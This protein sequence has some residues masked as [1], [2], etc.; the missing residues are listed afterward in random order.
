MG[1]SDIS[2]IAG[3]YTLGCRCT[4]TTAALNEGKLQNAERGM[5]W[6]VEWNVEWNT[7]SL[8]LRNEGECHVPSETNLSKSIH[9]SGFLPALRDYIQSTSSSI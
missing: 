5:E 2:Q 4:Q 1:G 9:S 8:R 6:N 3:V 7:R